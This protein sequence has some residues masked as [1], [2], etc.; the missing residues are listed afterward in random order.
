VVVAVLDTGVS[1]VA[2]LSGQLLPGRTYL[3][4][5]VT[6]GADD[7]HG[8]GTHVAGTIAAIA[9]NAL[10]V[11]GVA[12]E[13]K[14]LPVKVLDSQ[15]SGSSLDIAAAIVWAVDQ[16]AGV[17]N[18]SLGG[19]SVSHYD[20]AV[21]YAVQQGVVVVAAAGNS[22]PTLNTVSYPAALPTTIAVAAIGDTKSPATFSTRGSY[23]DLAAPGVDILST[24]YETGWYSYSSGTSMAAPHVAGVAALLRA[25]HPGATAAQV[26]TA[27]ESSLEDIH[28]PG[29]DTATGWGLID[30]EAALGA[31]DAVIPPPS[32][33]TTTT[34]TTTTTAPPTT[35]TTT[36][37]TPP[38]TTPPTTTPLPWPAPASVSVAITGRDIKVSAEPVP[39]AV[40][41][42]LRR[43]G[44]LVASS[45]VPLFID[46]GRAR[47]AA[48]IAYQVRALD[49]SGAAGSPT[50]TSVTIT[51]PRRARITNVKVG[52]RVKKGRTVVLSLSRQPRGTRVQIYHNGK[53]VRDARAATSVKV[54]V[55]AGRARFE[56]YVWDNKG[57]SGSSNKVRVTIP[58]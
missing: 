21:D 22:G 41:Y 26:R 49:P 14:I 56:V 29:F 7:D 46:V 11:A 35:T 39:G 13:T 15:G 47:N 44:V 55:P 42:Q 23:V 6:E 37:T 17:L 27:I 3:A 12:P 8:H 10:G 32:S 30:A 45:Q 2:D 34:T 9:D 43:N 4:G 51:P 31:L 16:G 38:A 40:G 25:A 24:Y 54:V 28:T 19:P 50:D 53:L 5:T 20:T 1:E 33:T 48:T 36:T 57:Y 58:R 52:S 18:L